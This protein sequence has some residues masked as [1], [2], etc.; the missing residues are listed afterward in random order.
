M[1]INI[2]IGLFEL[3]FMALYLILPNYF[4]VEISSML[5]LITGS[6]LVLIIWIIGYVL[7]NNGIIKLRIFNSKKTKIIFIFYFCVR[8]LT[9]VYYISV[10]NE[11]LKEILVIV[12]EELIVLW[13]I[14]Q[15]INTQDKIE[16]SLDVMIKVSIII[17]IITIIGVFLGKNLFY[18]LNIV[19]RTMLMADY[20][21]MGLIRAEAGFGHP[22]YYGI[23]CI[24]M[25]IIALQFMEKYKDKKI[26]CIIFLL[27]ICALILANSRGSI[28]A[29]FIV[30]IYYLS[31]KN[32]ATLVKYLKYLLIAGL[33]FI[34]MILIFPN[35]L[36]FTEDIFK[37]I[38]KIFNNDVEIVN[39]GSNQNGLESRFNQITQVSYSL[40]Q[41]FW[42]GLGPSAQTRNVLKWYNPYNEKWETSTSFDVGY[43][44]IICQY[45]ILGAI[46]YFGL[47]CYI[48]KIVFNKK[49]KNDYVMQIFK[50]SFLSYFVMMMSV[51]GLHK[52]FWILTGLLVSYYNIV[53]KEEKK[54]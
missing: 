42:F 9:N 44:A 38:I 3:I 33:L 2:K 5:P 4:A 23:Y 36:K 6:R 49:Y 45:G 29:L 43:F 27:N 15:N 1:K 52:M 14:V 10:T 47:Y 11:A 7:L 8:I 51:S 54:Y 37:S 39:Y 48:L 50:Y 20:S 19:N 46:A 28:I 17:N 32:F 21:R 26:Y 12:L 13:L 40:E 16:K 53:E 25:A 18:Y 31:Q 22:V 34:L 35:I 41:N 24:V 30:F